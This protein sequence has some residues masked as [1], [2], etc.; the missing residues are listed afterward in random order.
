MGRNHHLNEQTYT[1]RLWFAKRGL[2]SSACNFLGSYFAL[3]PMLHTGI[4]HVIPSMFMMETYTAIV[5][6][7]FALKPRAPL[8]LPC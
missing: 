8:T 2:A 7:S 3:S 6:W 4:Y 1:Y 5:P